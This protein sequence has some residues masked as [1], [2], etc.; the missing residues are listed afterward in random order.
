VNLGGSK[1]RLVGATKELSLQ[2]HQTKNQW[3]DA[4]SREFE[5]RYIQELQVNVDKAVAVIEL[6]DEVLKKVRKDCE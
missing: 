6:L 3:R 4:R 5:R 2:W 1:S